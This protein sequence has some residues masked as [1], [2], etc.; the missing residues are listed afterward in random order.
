MPRILDRALR[1]AAA[2]LAVLTLSLAAGCAGNSAVLS[3]V[4]YDLGPATSVVT[5]GPGPR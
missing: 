4:R 5:A 1:P 3:N 2:A